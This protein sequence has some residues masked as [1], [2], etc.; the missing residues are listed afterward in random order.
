[1][2]KRYVYQLVI[3]YPDVRPSDE[4]ADRRGWH[5]PAGDDPKW[6]RERFYLSQSGAEGRAGLLRSLGCQVVILQSEPLTF[7]GVERHFETLNRRTV[8]G[9]QQLAESLENTDDLPVALR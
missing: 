5:W 2:R 6:P 7:Q 9:L 1:M 4:L 3:D 8:E